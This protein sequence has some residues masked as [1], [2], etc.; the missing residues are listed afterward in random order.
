MCTCYVGGLG[1]RG[2]FSLLHLYDKRK[3][4]L[5]QR[6]ST[7]ELNKINPTSINFLK[8]SKSAS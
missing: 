3:M 6:D 1:G 5:F 2:S 8:N 4:K 7:T